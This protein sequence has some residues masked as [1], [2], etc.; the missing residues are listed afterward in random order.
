MG[1]KMDGNVKFRNFLKKLS[2][3][4]TGVTVRELRMLLY[5]ILPIRDLDQSDI[6]LY[7]FNKLN[8]HGFISKTDVRLLLDISEVTMLSS[9]TDCINKYKKNNCTTNTV[10]LTKYRKTLFIALKNVGG[11][12]LIKLTAFYKLSAFNFDNIWDVV[13]HIEKAGHLDSQQKIKM[14]ATVLNK[15]SEH[16]LLAT[17]YQPA[18]IQTLEPTLAARPASAPEQTQ[19][20]TALT[21]HQFIQLKQIVADWFDQF[22]LIG[23]IKVLYKD[24]VPDKARIENASSMMELLN[25]LCIYKGLNHNNPNLIYDTITVT[26]QDGVWDRIYRMP[27]LELLRP[28][29]EERDVSFSEYRHMIMRLGNS[30]SPSDTRQISEMY[31]E[32]YLKPY[33]DSWSLIVDL[34]RNLILSERNMMKFIEVLREVRLN[35]VVESVNFVDTN[36]SRSIRDYLRTKQKAKFKEPKIACSLKTGLIVGIFAIAIAIA[37]FAIAIAIAIAFK[38]PS[39]DEI[40][41]T[42]LK[43]QQK[44]I[45]RPPNIRPPTWNKYVGRYDIS[46]MFTDPVLFTTYTVRRGKKK[47]HISLKE[48]LSII[49]SIKPCKVLMT[50]NGGSGKTCLLQYIS[51]NWATNSDPTFAD[52]ILFLINARDIKEGQS[53]TDLIVDNFRKS[54]FNNKGSPNRTTINHFIQKYDR[55][56]VVLVDGFDELKSGVD[57]PMILKGEELEHSTVILTSRPGFT[58]QLHRYYDVHVTV[59]GFAAENIKHYITRYFKF[60]EKPDLGQSLIKAFKLDSHDKRVWGGDHKNIFELFSSP[61]LLLKMCTSWQHKPVIPTD[62]KQYLKEIFRSVINQS[63]NRSDKYT[64]NPISAFDEIP[65]D[66]ENAILIL[67]NISYI[68]LQKNVLHFTERE[69]R[70][71]VKHETLELSLKLG[72]V[73]EDPPTFNDHFEDIYRFPHRLLSE[74]LAGYYLSNKIETLDSEEC[75]KIRTNTY[76]HMTRAFTI[77]FLGPNADKLMKHWLANRPSNYYSFSKYFKY[78]NQEYKQ[79]V[80]KSLDELITQKELEKDFDYL[81]NSFKTFLRNDRLHLIQ[82]LKLFLDELTKYQNIVLHNVESIINTSNEHSSE[83]VCKIVAH[84]SIILQLYKAEY[85]IMPPVHDR[86][87]IKLFKKWGDRALTIL[88]NEWKTYHLVEEIRS[89]YYIEDHEHLTGLQMCKLFQT[90]PD[91]EVLYIRLSSDSEK[92]NNQRILSVIWECSSTLVKLKKI[93]ISSQN[94]SYEW[95]FLRSHIIF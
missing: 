3:H 47:H 24:L 32:T 51:Y 68:G 67:G 43:A 76:L 50:G 27:E 18:V 71:T 39:E 48:L 44:K 91:L 21:T 85:E 54:F 33:E 20:T 86:Y 53:I 93:R 38:P 87:L 61:F 30:M 2:K 36:E 82:L 31:E 69:L 15:V 79:T 89:F 59:E 84:M 29:T 72:F 56:L 12:D 78:V 37:I 55:E 95:D 62:F 94:R 90:F 23:M 42:F 1:L 4:Y 74:A 92:L 28:K 81:S 64:T 75:E 17:P 58:V 13:Y 19:I 16:I 77:S 10:C 26:K 25:L 41:R 5:G 52:K 70:G 45:F 49:N 40:I 6:A 35:H 66:Y 57:I 73:Y 80:L 46:K 7:L 34:E 9:A 88:S 22:R 8:D 14:F 83:N 63:I 65:P 11:N 60:I